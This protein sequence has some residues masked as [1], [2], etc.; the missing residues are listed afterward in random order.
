M[1][2][3]AGVKLDVEF[4]DCKRFYTADTF[5]R[6]QE[7][8][9]KKLQ[10]LP[11]YQLVI[12]A[13]DD[14]L[15]FALD[16]RAQLFPDLPLVFFGV[17]NQTL[18]QSL[19]G[20]AL[21]AGVVEAVSMRE[22]LDALWQML[23]RAR[24]VVALTDATP[25]GQADLATYLALQSAYPGKELAVVSLQD[26]TWR[27]A[28]RALDALT[29]SD[30]ALLL[31]SAYRDKANVTKEFAES[32]DWVLVHTR[33][34]VFHLWHHGLGEGVVGGKLISHYDQA[35]AAGGIALDILNGRA[36]GTIPVMA[37]S[38]V[39]AYYFDQ[40][41]LDRFGIKASTV[42][43]GAVILNKKKSM[44]DEYG[45]ELVALCATV[46][47]LGACVIWL[48]V[49]ARRYRRAER[50]AKARELESRRA[51]E[52][53][54]QSENTL[55]S[56]F[57][58]APVGAGLVVDR[59]IL[60]AN[61]LLCRMTGYSEQELLGRNA[62]MLYPD[63]GEYELV[64]REK[65][66]Q[67]FEHG[68]GTVETRWIRKDRTIIDVL[69]SST[70]LEREDLS[71]GVVF[72]AL[73]ISE[74]KAA[75]V[76]LRQ[77]Q[78]EFQSI[79]ENSQVGILLLRGGR[80]IALANQRVADILGYESP[81]ELTGAS[82]R[83][84]HLD[85]AHYL[86]FGENYYKPLAWGK[87]TQLE[88]QFRRKDGTAIW[89]ILSGKALDPVDLNKGVIWVMDDLTRRKTLEAQLTEAK[90]VAEAAN[91]AKSE[92]LANM[93]HEIRTPLNG[94]IGMLQLLQL[95][96]ITPEQAEYVT[97]AV[98][99]SRRL[100]RL[101]SDILDLSRV[102]AGKLEIVMYPFDFKDAMEAVLQ[103]FAP[104]AMQKRLELRMTINPSI[105]EWLRGDAPRLQQ[106]LSNLIGNALKFTTTGHVEVE[107]HP[108]PARNSLEYRVLFSVTDTGIGIP[109]NKMALLFTPFSQVSQGYQRE[110]QGAGLGL[111][112]C[113]RLVNLMGG[114][115]AIESQ[116]GVGTSVYFC[117]TFGLA[118][119]P[120][121][122][123][124]SVQQASGYGLS[125]LLVEDDPA[126]QLSTMRLV[127]LLGHRVVAVA[128]GQQAL[129]TLKTGRF[130]LVLMDIQM[131]GMD[132]MEATRR[133]RD[134]A[135]GPDKAG[136]PILALTAYA[137]AGDRE[138]F[139]AAGMDGYL[140]KPVELPILEQAIRQGVACPRQSP[141]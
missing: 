74:R 57:L 93:S 47:L 141:H 91:L 86:E 128:D 110:F 81:D 63:D 43:A 65:Y 95:T 9:Q 15:R 119:C 73:D 48:F 35:K 44:F 29:A 108:L 116:A 140:S 121:E 1:L 34:P 118:D 24:R 133:I 67:I 32:L 123:D 112:I 87:Q 42:P 69:L 104:T 41:V 5:P 26:L 92:F 38:E 117:I 105:P 132:G 120:A 126:N 51:E 136:I 13:D 96:A 71:K 60:R 130:D 115:I 23:P 52:A 100:T 56:I 30:D 70:P 61:A 10:A 78:Q 27:Q 138:R 46:G 68:T 125:L 83:G 88:Y 33:V 6:F 137:M 122:T 106:V 72:T 76:T 135:A 75:E 89:C 58:A 12:V 82:V 2:D 21:T 7:M 8:L 53:L 50:H 98:Q 79:F 20:D 107:A 139:L 54:R 36:P 64:G 80:Q 84:L 22:T 17:N 85:E 134:G 3:P 11:P 39:N 25:S 102:E 129:E 90:E 37:S 45:A 14:A 109:D 77:A 94:I 31:L 19:S 16:T 124:A 66:R 59:V 62:R 113:R 114:N 97:T 18:A 127:E 40:A 103:L 111:S 99:S 49:L 131:P 28:E 55:T 101:L 4:M